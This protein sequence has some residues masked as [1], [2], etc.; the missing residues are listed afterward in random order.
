MLPVSLFMHLEIR[1]KYCI[2]SQFKKFNISQS[3][4]SI[5]V[6]S[7]LTPTVVYYIYK[8]SK[9]WYFAYLMSNTVQGHLKVK[10]KL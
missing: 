7:S 8:D 2:T 5:S 4:K 3:M 6:N 1:G 10:V 9:D